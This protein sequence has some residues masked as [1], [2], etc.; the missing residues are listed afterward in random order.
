[1]KR[2]L[3]LLISICL[4]ACTCSACGEQTLADEKD[5]AVLSTLPSNSQSNVGSAEITESGPTSSGMEEPVP[6][7]EEFEAEDDTSDGAQSY[8]FGS[9]EQDGDLGNGNEALEWVV[10]KETDDAMLIVSKYALDQ[11]KFHETLED[12]TWEHCTLRTWLNDEFIDIAFTDSEQSRI[13]E[14]VVSAEDNAVFGTDAGNDT[15]DRVFLLSTSEA[16]LYFPTNA[17]RVCQ[18]TA[19]AC[20]K[21]AMISSVKAEQ[22]NCWWGLRTP[23]DQY[24]SHIAYVAPRGEVYDGENYE[25]GSNVDSEIMALRPAMWIT[26]D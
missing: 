10:L 12:I 21:G 24:Q 15:L 5:N 9:Y 25:Y 22:G 8:V 2:I 19:Y 14:T 18:P 7:D 11:K 16:L 17:D 3:V 4:V 20:E 23:G 13:L 6:T 1:M 26:V